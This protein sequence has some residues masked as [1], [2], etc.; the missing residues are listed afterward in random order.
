MGLMK[1]IIDSIKGKLKNDKKIVLKLISTSFTRGLAAIGTFV[2][3]FVLA[4]YLGVSDFGYFMLAY[5]IL[6]GLGFLV[7]FGMPIAILRFAGIMYAEKEFGKIKK[8]QRDVAIVTLAT[9]TVL[10]IVLIVSRDFLE[11][12][13]FDQVDVR[14]MLLMFAFSLPF[15]SFATVQSSFMK[16]FERPEIA[17]F[18]EVGLTTLIVGSSIAVLAWF[19]LQIDSYIASIVFLLASIVVVIFGYFTLKRIFRKSTEGITVISEDYYNFYPTLPDYALSAIAGYL[20]K[21]SPIIVLGIYASAKDIGLYS[22]ANSTAFLI[23]FILWIVSAVYAPH[24][25]RFHSQGKTKEL[26]ESVRSSILYLLIIAT[27]I[28]L[29]IISFPTAI[30]GFFG[31]EFEEGKTALIILAIAQLFNV[32]TGPVYFLLNMTGHQKY[33][34]NIVFLT[35]LVSV[36]SVFLLVPYYSF[37]GAAIATA[38]C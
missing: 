26:R 9:S 13:F 30:L 21:F 20:L 4:K 3:N 34:R 33:L 14:G 15:Y 31:Q 37:I 2:F 29:I 12:Q 32:S 22:L 18:F 7:R 11:V 23:S 10:G 19:G 8:L 25:A 5:S 36:V 24:F 16:A 1:K 6:I 38:I 35:A 28:F 27:P 17:P